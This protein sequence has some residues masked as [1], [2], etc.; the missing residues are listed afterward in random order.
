MSVLSND[1]SI[2]YLYLSNFQIIEMNESMNGFCLLRAIGS[3]LFCNANQTHSNRF[4]IE[5]DEKFNIRTRANEICHDQ[6]N[7]SFFQSDMIKRNVLI[8]RRCVMRCDVL[9]SAMLC[10]MVRV[11]VCYVDILYHQ[12]VYRDLND[13]LFFFFFFF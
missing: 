10:A 12:P 8:N 9:S 1:L 3:F 13:F 5:F 2:I 7:S 6:R 4:T 11:C